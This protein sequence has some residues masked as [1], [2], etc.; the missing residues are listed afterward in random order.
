M[1]QKFKNIVLII[2]CCIAISSLAQMPGTK[3]FT[4]GAE[5][6]EPPHINTIYQLKNGYI[7]LG[8][9]KGLYKF[10]G[11]TFS[12][13]EQAENVPDTVTSICELTDKEI[14]IGYSNGFI[15]HLQNNQ[16]VTDSI[17]EG[18]PKVAVTKIIA[19]KNNVVWLAT[20]GEGVY[21]YK[22]K[23]LYNIDTADGLTDDFVYD[24]CAGNANQVVAATDKGINIC[25]AEGK[26]KVTEHYT[27]V[28]GL[29]DNIVRSLFITEREKVWL[30]MQDG[31]VSKYD[32]I[33]RDASKK[34][35]WQYGQV[36]AITVIN[37][38]VFVATEDN[39][40]LVFNRDANDNISGLQYKDDQLKKIS[41]ML[42]D[43]EGNIWLG[44]NNLLIRSSAS[45]VQPLITLDKT[46]TE[47][48]HSLLWSRD[49]SIWFN[50]ITGVTQLKESNGMWEQKNFLIP[51]VNGASISTIFEDIKGL[52]W[53]GTLGKGIIILNPVTGTQYVLKEIPELIN[54]NVISITGRDSS[55]WISAFEATVRVNL[56]KDGMSSINYAGEQNLGNKYVYNILQDKYNNV[57]FAT[58]GKGI[59]KYQNGKFSPLQQPAG[60]YGNVVYKMIED[61]NGN[62]WF[63]TYDKGLIKYD[64]KTF[65]RF[66]TSQGLSDMNI[67]GLSIS[68]DNIFLI[69][70]N[71]VDLI[72]TKSGNITYLD[73]DQGINNI[74]TDLNALATDKNGNVYFVAD[75]IL[76]KY[77]SAKEI[78]LR[79]IVMIDRIQL[80]LN[81]I[82]VKNG[83]VFKYNENNLS[84]YYTGLYYSQSNRIQYQ[85]KLEGYDK[86]WVST[87]DR[88]KN[89]P[90]LPPGTYTFKVRVSLNQNF[91][92]SSE[93]AYTFTIEQPFW[94]QLWFI[95]LSVI[96][97][98]AILYVIIKQREKS[99]EKYNK[100]EREKIRS[101]LETLRNQINPHFLFNSFNTLISEIEENPDKAVLYVEHLSD[102]YRNI[103]VHREK[104]LISLQEEIYILKDYCFI[105]QKRYGEAL[106]ISITIP[107]EQQKIY[108][109]VPLALQ[110]LFENAVKHNTIS[111]A[112]PLCIELFTEN[113]E[114]LIVR[115]NIN[116]KFTPEKGSSMGLQNIQK[117]YLLLSNKNVIV[118]NDGKSFI[119]KIPLI[120]P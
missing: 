53:I 28:N 50:T 90:Q 37:T 52:I 35:N 108:Y 76:Y 77:N 20:A 118:E 39:G 18:F 22:N 21:F 80:F 109:I 6:Q 120:K 116:K 92:A 107:A 2:C 89:F 113:D 103:V 96:A 95:A 114:C 34:L 19:T 91:S 38:S 67:T 106:K 72:N 26:N 115:N 83:H 69:H 97:L 33:T 41:C 54:T 84:F 1:V 117:R 111:A 49:S 119:V 13:F 5:Y 14:L 94:R 27:S 15:G 64:G 112:H 44:G 68:G 31:G 87:K 7:L 79:P 93:A 82:N 74:N 9:T 73:A 51:N 42:L 8:T 65:T 24:L 85:Y 23:R 12:P 56:Q 61:S 10:D 101:Q 71:N 62:T 25:T 88:L 102:F 110:L 59:I 78:V 48:L 43:H 55:I 60:G 99:I 81:D 63:S 46:T 100:L 45:N 16:I 98:A 104:D 66:T 70:K 58:D 17:E 30:G 29:P 32:I 36:N 40:L 75:S 57:W 3:I 105:Q 4:L 47:N 86:N 11:I